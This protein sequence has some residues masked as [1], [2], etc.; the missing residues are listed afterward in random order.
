MK[1]TIIMPTYNDC[2]SI[3]ETL[4]SIIEQTHQD[5]EL[6]ISD[7]GSTDDTK[8][9]VENYIKTK[10]EK[11]IKYFY[12]D[13][14]DQ[15]NAI[16]NVLDKATG[17]YIH[18]LH[19]DDKFNNKYVL[20]KVNKELE[21]EKVDAL[22]SNYVVTMNEKS[23]IIG[24]IKYP[25][26]TKKE[27]IMATQLLWLG[28][29]YYC[30][31]AFFKKDVYKN[32][33]K[34]NYLTWNTPYWLN[35]N[36]EPFMLNV[37]TVSYPFF[38]YRV[39]EGNYINNEIGQ[40]NVISGELR[41][42]IHLL[43]HFNIPNYKFQYFVFRLFNKIG[44]RDLFRPIYKKGETKNKAE[45][46]KFI[47]NKR[48]KDE[49]IHKYPHLESLIRFFE[50]YQ[51][52]TITIDKIDK[53]EK[54]YQGKDMRFFN[55]KIVAGDISDLYKKMFKEM[56]KGFNTIATTKENKEKIEDTIKFLNLYPFVNVK[57]IERK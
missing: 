40:L 12:Q 21:T 27:Y 45:I 30:D 36:G 32:D 34:Y 37:K 3:T 56:K 48:Y 35:Y 1:F 57:I 8:T 49:E 5:W 7:D 43:K 20:E 51:D 47:I 6:L 42:A 16:I 23:E 28:R 11:R 44:L 18:I 9:I 13:N 26:Y 52:R 55:K 10:K 25:K 50:N 29:Q 2:E 38:N 15:L 54:I 22:F 31:V 46:I 53:N 33:V 41:T 14:Q 39:F 17:D 19:S 24:D 4:D